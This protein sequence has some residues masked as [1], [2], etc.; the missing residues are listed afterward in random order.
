[1]SEE[2]ERYFDRI[3]GRLD[4]IIELLKE[5]RRRERDE[6]WGETPKPPSPP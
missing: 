2:D 4:E 5:I 1:M 3:V 6:I